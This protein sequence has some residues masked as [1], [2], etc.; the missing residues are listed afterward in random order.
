MRLLKTILGGYASSRLFTE[1]REKRGLCYTIRAVESAYVDT[2]VFGITAGLDA[3]RLTEALSAIWG[4]V[5]KMAAKPV[6][7]AELERAREYLKGSM[8]ISL[9]GTYSLAWWR[10]DQ[11]LCEGKL[12]ELEQINRYLDSVTAADIQ[13]L[14]REILQPKGLGVVLVGPP[15]KLDALRQ[16]VV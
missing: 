7:A 9:E 12:L 15:V 10:A 3:N 6:E 8:A 4:E 13:S 14:A 1:I 11:W 2:G 5:G 16:I